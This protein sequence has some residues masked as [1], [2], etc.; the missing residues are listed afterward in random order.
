[1]ICTN[2]TAQFAT[3]PSSNQTMWHLFVFIMIFWRPVRTIYSFDG[4]SHNRESPFFLKA[5]QCK[6][7][8]KHQLQFCD[9]HFS[10]HPEKSK[11]VLFSETVML[12]IW[13]ELRTC[14]S[15][16]LKDVC[17]S[18][19]FQRALKPLNIRPE[20]PK[21]IRAQ[22]ALGSSSVTNI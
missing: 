18:Q 9:Q 5:R 21:L 13:P 4:D 2:C 10:P 22:R 6:T 1:M 3:E 12:Y 14:L 15:K 19:P 7:E 17:P 16:H 20:A 8:I 11:R